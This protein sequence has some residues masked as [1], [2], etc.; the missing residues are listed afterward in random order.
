MGYPCC[1]DVEGQ[2]NRLFQR[3]VGPARFERRP[4]N[5]ET[6]RIEDGCR[7]ATILESA[8]RS[9]LFWFCANFTTDL[10]SVSIYFAHTQNPLKTR[11]CRGLQDRGT[12]P[13]IRNVEN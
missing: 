9:C 7:G 3:R 10:F 2:G 4:T 6:S 1:N 13:T 8:T 5:K 12:R 11:P